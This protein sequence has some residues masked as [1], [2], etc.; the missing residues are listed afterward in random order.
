MA[1]G[2][3]DKS[4][5]V[6]LLLAFFL[7]VFGGHRFYAG[8]PETGALMLITLGGL[9][10]WWLYDLILVAA[11]GFRDGDNRLISRWE[12]ESD[13]SGAAPLPGEVLEEL[14]ALRHEVA[15]LAE[16]MDF[17]ERLLARPT[18]VEPVSRPRE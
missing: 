10:L 16:R 4:R 14:D 12:P 11:G 1:D 15:E 17:T 13:A 8:R 7:G 2:P 3:S 18:S 6:A 5:T 9:G